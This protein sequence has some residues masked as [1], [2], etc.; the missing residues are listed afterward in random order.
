MVPCS[1]RLNTALMPGLLGLRGLGAGRGRAPCRGGGGTAAPAGSDAT[2]APGTAE[3]GLATAGEERLAGYLCGWES[4]FVGLLLW[5]G[6]IRL[7]E[8]LIDCFRWFMD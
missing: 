3:K 7:V 1:L 2:P 4:F 6:E 5:D 8:V